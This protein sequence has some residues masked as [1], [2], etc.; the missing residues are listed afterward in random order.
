M[1]NW[2]KRMR[3]VQ[4]G[5]RILEL[6]AAIGLLILFILVTKV[7]P[8]TSWITRITVGAFAPQNPPNL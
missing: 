3:K 6:N 4:L 5:F 2:I 1:K 8:L 7:D